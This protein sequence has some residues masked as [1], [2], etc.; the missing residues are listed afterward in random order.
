MTPSFSGSSKQLQRNAQMEDRGPNHPSEF[1]TGD[2]LL[3]T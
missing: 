2:N 1:I 3:K